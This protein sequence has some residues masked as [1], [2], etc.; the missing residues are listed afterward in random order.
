MIKKTL[1]CIGFIFLMT[2]CQFNCTRIK[3][4]NKPV[5]D[6]RLQY[7]VKFERARLRTLDDRVIIAENAILNNNSRMLSYLKDKET[8]SVGLSSLTNLEYSNT[9]FSAYGAIIGGTL[10]IA[11]P[12]ILIDDGGSSKNQG[13][14]DVVKFEGLSKALAVLIA[15]PFGIYIGHQLGSGYY[16]NWQEYP[17]NRNESVP[18]PVYNS[19]PSGTMF[20]RWKIPLHR[21]KPF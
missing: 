3:E 8:V 19:P 6:N 10:G 9:N 17:L 16:I 2:C 15:L 13:D 20:L 7:E 12:V 1:K 11:L 4:M 21:L 5:E 14:G 18:F